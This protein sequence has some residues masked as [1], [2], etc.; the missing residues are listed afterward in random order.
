MMVADRSPAAALNPARAAALA[1]PS[2]HWASQGGGFLA[3]S[4]LGQDG[5]LAGL[6]SDDS[7][8]PETLIGLD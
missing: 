4:R 7:C 1:S 8:L 5:F 6:F 3:R 2:T